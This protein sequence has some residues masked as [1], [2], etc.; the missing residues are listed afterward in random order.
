VELPTVLTMRDPAD[1]SP[2]ATPLYSYCKI[3]NKP[4]FLSSKRRGKKSEVF[5]AL[6]WTNPE[7]STT[8][9]L[10]QIGMSR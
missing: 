8:S 4:W 5:Y 6:N 1:M 7:W 10:L 2:F 3:N 9:E